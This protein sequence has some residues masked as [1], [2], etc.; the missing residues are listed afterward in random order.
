[1]SKELNE[2]QE[3]A[4][5]L[6]TSG[7]TCSAVAAEL[8]VT[9]ETISRWKRKPEFNQRLELSLEEVRDMARARISAMMD[10]ALGVLESNL[11]ATQSSEIRTRTAIKIM[12]LFGNPKQGYFKEPINQEKDNRVIVFRFP[13]DQA[14][15]SRRGVEFEGS[16]A[17]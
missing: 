8:G 6:L 16:E 7:K 2:S 10:G 12:E 14:Q 5:V 11:S 1:M 13:M 3:L 15:T 17:E 4:V 9:R